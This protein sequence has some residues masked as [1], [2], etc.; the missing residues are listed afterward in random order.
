MK[1]SGSVRPDCGGAFYGESVS[2]PGAA[3]L[4]WVTGADATKGQDEANSLHALSAALR[5]GLMNS[6]KLGRTDPTALR[7][8]VN[9]DTKK[10][11]RQEDLQ[12]PEAIPALVQLLQAEDKATREFLVEVLAGIKGKS[13]S[14]VL[15][16][17][18]LFD[19]SPDV[20]EQAVA[21]LADRPE[22]EYR[23]IL[24]AGFRYPWPAVADH[25]AEAVVALDRR[26]YVGRLVSL[27]KEPDP[28]TPFADAKGRLVTR[29]LVRL[30][31]L[32]NCLMCHP[33]SYSDRDLVRGLIPSPGKP[34]PP[35]YYTSS[36]G[37]FARADVT[38]L[39]QDFSVLQPVP[40]P[41]Q[42]PGQQR[43]DYLVRVR[44]ASKD[45]TLR[46]SRPRTDVTPGASPTTEAKSG[47]DKDQHPEKAA[48]LFALRKLTGKDLGNTHAAWAAV[49]NDDTKP[50]GD[51]PGE[52]DGRAAKLIA[53]VVAAPPAKR[54][55]LLVVCHS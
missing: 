10:G 18:A 11:V 54:M 24:M 55:A 4:P 43:Y 42:W 34:P 40:N 16:Q 26:E 47:D 35:L 17:R 48:L 22:Q 9:S 49:L 45:D 25:A 28:R 20:R 33:P 21:G 52:A 37:S 36:R 23:D 53:E 1:K 31:H 39:R 15:A 12:K 41:L 44:P 51:T 3:S 7:R 14:A 38:Y 8:L 6:S 29:E 19:L 13:A 30:N 2:K 5:A 32:S 50:K 46:A 27:L